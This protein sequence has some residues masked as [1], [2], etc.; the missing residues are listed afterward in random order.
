MPK[1]L[2]EFLHER[3][4]AGDFLELTESDYKF[5]HENAP[6]AAHVPWDAD[7]PGTIVLV[8]VPRTADV[9]PKAASKSKSQ[10]Q[11]EKQAQETET[12][13]RKEREER[14]HK[15]QTRDHAIKEHRSK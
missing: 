10:L 1:D 12:K 11:A 13:S 6:W 14:D 8:H 2:H 7:E 3:V 9:A 5:V 15:A 4:N